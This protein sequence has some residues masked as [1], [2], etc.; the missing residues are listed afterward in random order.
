MIRRLSAAFVPLALAF[1]AVGCAATDS[2]AGSDDEYSDAALEVP[3]TADPERTQKDLD[4]EELFAKGQA[5]REA[6]EWTDAR[7]HFKDIYEDFPASP[8]APEAQ[9]QAAECRYGA[10]KYYAAG[11]AFAKYIE[12][13][14]LSPHVNV[15]EKRMY[16]IGEYLIEDGERGL[17]GTGW[18]KTSEDGISILRKL[19]TLLPTGTYADDALMRIGRFRAE[20]RDFVGAELTLEELLKNYSDSEWRLEA[21]FL[22]AWTYRKDNRGPEY[23]GE[24]LRRARAHFLAYVDVASRDAGRAEEFADRIAAAR[25]EVDLI[26]EDLARKALARAG[27]YKRSGRTDA[28]RFVLEDA[29]QR[30]GSTESG[31]EAGV[32]AAEMSGAD[33]AE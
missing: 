22:L 2:G 28:A 12:D 7:D 4:A 16:D 18:F 1:V 13:R 3:T 27:F 6:G 24:K 30:W 8:L 21:R 5:A 31:R 23:D 33:S 9:F 29:A 32:R 15:V 17:W 25:A 20:K 14:P 11:N 10:E 19:T 26:D